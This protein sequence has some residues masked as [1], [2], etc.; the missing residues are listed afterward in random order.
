MP[1]LVSLGKFHSH[2]HFGVSFFIYSF[3]PFD[4]GNTDQLTAKEGAELVIWCSL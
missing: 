3:W 4:D 2:Y 1:A